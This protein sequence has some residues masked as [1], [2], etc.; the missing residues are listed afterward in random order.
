[1]NMAE[2][3]RRASGGAQTAVTEAAYLPETQPQV[4]AAIVE[5]EEYIDIRSDAPAIPGG[6]TVR[7]E[8]TLGPEQIALLMRSVLQTQHTVLTSREAAA[9]LRITPHAIE[10]MAAR[11]EVPAFQVEGKW[12]FARTAIDEWMSERVKEVSA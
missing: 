8:L 9:V 6:K 2:A 4:V 3:I 12:R 10:Q 5:T 7:L 11:A 1:M